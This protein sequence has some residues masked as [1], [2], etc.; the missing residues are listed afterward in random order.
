M[1]RRSTPRHAQTARD[2]GF[3]MQF[4]AE[5]PWHFAPSDRIVPGVTKGR[6]TAFI[7]CE[8]PNV[9]NSIACYLRLPQP[10]P[11]APLLSGGTRVR[12]LWSDTKWLQLLLDDCCTCRLEYNAIHTTFNRRTEP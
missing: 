5:T 10:T 8:R 3:A 1:S 2:L 6:V 11:L 12:I 4:N 7:P 9:K